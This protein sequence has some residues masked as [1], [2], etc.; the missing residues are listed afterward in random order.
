MPDADNPQPTPPTDASTLSPSDQDK[1]PH[2]DLSG[3]ADEDDAEG[4]TTLTF[5]SPPPVGNPR[6]TTP[7]DESPSDRYVREHP[8]LIKDPDPGLAE[9]ESELIFIA[10]PPDD[11]DTPEP[12]VRSSK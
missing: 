4:D 6:P 7:T 8:R 10:S 9:G 11:D 1:Y 3:E 5:I 12:E 2:L